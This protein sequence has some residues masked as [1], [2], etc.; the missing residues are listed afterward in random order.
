MIKIEIRI[1][2]LMSFF[3]IDIINPINKRKR[4]IL[5]IM[6]KVKK[7]ELIVSIN[8]FSSDIIYINA[9]PPQG[10]EVFTELLLYDK[11]IC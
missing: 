4:K 11:G 10:G 3:I 1:A 2:S 8:M 5:I 7:N 6:G 9:K